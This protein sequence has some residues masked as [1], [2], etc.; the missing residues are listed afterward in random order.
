M[1]DSPLVSVTGRA[2]LQRIDS[3]LAYVDSTRG[4][5]RQ[6]LR[7]LRFRLCRL[8][9]D[10]WAAEAGAGLDACVI[11]ALR[12]SALRVFGGNC[13]FADDDLALL[14][15]LAE[16]AVTAGLTDRLHKSILANIAKAAA[17]KAEGIEATEEPVRSEASQF[18]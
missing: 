8:E 12:E 14:T 9:E 17:K 11:G 10:L 4:E 18:Q 3:E 1:D 13:D 6:L 15:E 5:T 16:R 7:D 2:F